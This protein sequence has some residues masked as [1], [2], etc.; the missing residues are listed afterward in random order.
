VIYHYHCRCPARRL[1]ISH[2]DSVFGPNDLDEGD[3][4]VPDEVWPFLDDKPLENN[5]TA[6]GI[7][8]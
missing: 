2:E 7:A 1:L 4:E 5:P 6:D 8:L 3:F